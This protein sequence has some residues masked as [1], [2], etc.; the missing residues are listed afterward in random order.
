[1]IR[2]LLSNSKLVINNFIND[3]T[4]T[5]ILFYKRITKLQQVLKKVFFF[6]EALYLVKE[7]KTTFFFSQ[8]D[9]QTEVF[10]IENSLPTL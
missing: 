10:I 2:F 9:I 4:W 7:A 8:T 1:M 3:V 5:L 6:E